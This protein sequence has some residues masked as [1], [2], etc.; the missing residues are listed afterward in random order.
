MTITTPSGYVVEFKDEAELTY[1]DRRNIQRAMVR[2]LKIDADAAKAQDF[3]LTGDMLF[4]AQEATLKTILKS[5]MKDNKPVTGDLM[6][7]VMSWTNP[8]DGDAVFAQV[9]QAMAASPKAAT[10]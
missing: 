5:I 6:A 9:A 4:D 3:K 10:T 1:G 2:S 8:A 7:E